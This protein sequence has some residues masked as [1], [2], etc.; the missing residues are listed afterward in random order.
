MSHI[1]ISLV[2]LFLLDFTMLESGGFTT[3]PTI[4]PLEFYWF[5]FSPLK[6]VW[7]NYSSHIPRSRKICIFVFA[8]YLHYQILLILYFGKKIFSDRK[9]L[10]TKTL[11]A[12]LQHGQVFK[13]LFKIVLVDG[14]SPRTRTR[15]SFQIFDFLW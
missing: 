1:S 3:Q 6:L 14:F 9:T 10:F 4:Q 7:S 5:L 15:S 8:Y 12:H 11:S 13:R 2:N